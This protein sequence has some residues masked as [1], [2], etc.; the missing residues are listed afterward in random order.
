MAANRVPNFR[1]LDLF[2]GAGGFSW[3]LMKAGFEPAVAID[4]SPESVETL[5]VNFQHLGLRPLLKDLAI[6]SPKELKT[7]L[8][9]AGINSDF[10]IIVGGPPCQGWSQIG[11]AKLRSLRT[12]RGISSHDKDP[13]NGMYQVFVDYVKAFRPKAFIMENVP[14]MLSHFGKNAAE[15]VSAAMSSAGF[16]VTWQL[17]NASD[18]GVPQFRGRLF[19]VGI[20]NDLKFQFTFPAHKTARDKRLYPLVTV[21]EAFAD[22]PAIRNGARDWIRKYRPSKSMNAYASLMRKGAD[23]GTIFDH[24]CRTQ[25]KQDLEAFALMPQG[26][27]YRDLPKRLKR[28]R[29]DIF[30]DKYRKLVNS[31]PSWVVTA[32]LSRDCYSHIH[33]TQMRTISI[34]EAARLQS[35][36]DCFYF[37]G[38]FGSKMQL[39]GNAVPPLLIE[40]LARE[41][42]RQL[43]SKSDKQ[44]GRISSD[45]R[46]N[47]MKGQR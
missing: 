20:R 3:G 12:A 46:T 7:Y 4:H 31:R 35:F 24:V 21:R 40:H 39:I 28:Y 43:L 13:R 17:L 34:R 32:H 11:R 30:D 38:S 16:N 42:K 2:A 25:N 37:A 26:G 5:Q 47:P 18:F 9:A 10:D 41:L 23:P 22:L 15:E 45:V 33:P 44:A 27:R 19:F 6:F 36:P 14:G 29:D 1:F 8:R